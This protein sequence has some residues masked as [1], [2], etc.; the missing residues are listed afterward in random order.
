MKVYLAG[1][2][3]WAE[4]GIYNKE[5]NQKLYVL[6]SF[7]YI[8]DWMFPYIENHWEFLLDSGAFSFFGGTKVDWG[9]YVDKYIQFINEH[10]IKQFFELDLYS[11]IGV[12]ETEKLRAKIESKTQ[13]QSIPVFHRRLGIDYYKMLC[14]EYDYIAISASG[15]YESKWVRQDP[16]KLKMV[17]RYANNQGVKVHGLGYTKLPLLKEMKFH[18][19]D[20]T[21]WI[22]GNRGG[23]VYTHQRGEMKKTK[24]TKG[25]RLKAKDVAIHNFKE[26]VKL[27]KY[28]N[29]YL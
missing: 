28:A 5:I 12:K 22:Y 8:K 13:K 7:Y 24:V 21:A 29:V 25:K 11:V 16:E 14:A 2:W 3:P 1:Q 10:D 4:Q 6:E 9:K 17:I 23:F 18:S 26:W 27:Q 19:I 20:S 15:M